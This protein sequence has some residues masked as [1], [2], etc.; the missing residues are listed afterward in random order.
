MTLIRVVATAP[1]TYF[2]TMGWNTGGNGGGYCGVQYA[3]TLGRNYIF[4]LWNPTVANIVMI[5]F[6]FIW[7]KGLPM[8]KAQVA[9][10][11]SRNRVI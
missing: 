10:P 9:R 4:E 6:Q 11:C 2:E 8:E 7:F 5:P 3:G 1:T